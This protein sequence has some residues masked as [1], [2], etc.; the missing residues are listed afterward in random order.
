MDFTDQSTNKRRTA[1]VVKIE[2]LALCWARSDGHLFDLSFSWRTT[3]E[4]NSR[5][6][7]GGVDKQLLMLTHLL[8]FLILLLG[9]SGFPSPTSNQVEIN[10]RTT[11]MSQKDISFFFFFSFS[12]I[13]QYPLMEFAQMLWSSGKSLF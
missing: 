8:H 2:I 13:S 4:V 1:S 11:L 5:V 7:G 9:L 10:Y 3:E 6:Q 12:H